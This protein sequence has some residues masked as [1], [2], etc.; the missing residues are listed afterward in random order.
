MLSSAL[1]LIIAVSGGALLPSAGPPQSPW[2]F[3]LA[4]TTPA[5]VA[6]T[7]FWLARRRP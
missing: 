6:L 5:A 7:V 1:G 3:T 4:F 2:L